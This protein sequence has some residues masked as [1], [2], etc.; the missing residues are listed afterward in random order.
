MGFEPNYTI[1]SEIAR[2]LM[3][4]ESAREAVA[5]LPLNERVLAGLRQTARL[6]STHYSTQIE[7][8]RLTQAEVE[9]VL[10]RGEHIPQ[11]RRDEKEVKGYYAALDHAE[12]YAT[13]HTRITEPYIRKLHGLLMGGG[14]TRPKPTPYRDGQNVIRNAPSGE[15]VYMPPEA[16]DVPALMKDLVTWINQHAANVPVPIVAA[17]GH[18]QFATIHPYYDGNGRAARLLTN[19]ILHQHGYGLRGIYNLEE[20]Y[21]QN[22]REYYQAL[23]VGD[24]HNYYMGRAKAD[25]SGWVS[26]FLSG[27]TASFEAVR[28][29]ML[30]STHAGD[31]SDWIISLDARQRKVLPLFDEWAEITTSQIAKLLGL[32]PRGGRALAQKWVQE[33]FLVIANPSKRGRTYRLGATG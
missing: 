27:M 25:I 32:S 20:Y 22:L 16:A 24:G 13:D 6:V 9:Q 23:D 14:K 28:E 15:I 31:R 11:R 26:Y 30:D 2:D 4:I 18:Y 3:R 33:G 8:N 29:K 7:G 1:S 12:S 19:T 17:A 5:N 21:A 10:V